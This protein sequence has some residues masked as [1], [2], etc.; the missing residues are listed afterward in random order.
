LIQP[1]YLSKGDIIH[2]VAPAKNIRKDLI[3]KSIK[4]LEK[5]GFGVRLNQDLL[6]REGFFAGT[7]A[8][9]TEDFENAINHPEA[10]AIMALRGGYGCTRIIDKIDFSPLIEKPKWIIG[11]SDLTAFHARLFR[12]GI[13]SIHGSMPIF[14]LNPGNEISYQ[15]LLDLLTGNKIELKLPGNTKNRE[16]RGEGKFI[17]GNLSLIIDLLGTKDELNTEGHLLFIEEVDEYLYKI[18]RML[19]H[20]KRAGKLEKISGL[21]IGH[22][23]NIKDTS[24]PFKQTVHN[25]ISEVVSDYNY[26]VAFNFPIGHE[27]ENIS[28]PYGRHA[29]F[30]VEENSV[31]LVFSS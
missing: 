27:N 18:D 7:D 9:R 31:N 12:M 3:L 13:E 20:L 28:V 15:S 24:D 14:F 10:K 23:S 19:Q 6:D 4:L 8:E 17:G 25:I 11:F 30:K 2:L 21:I 5:S 16:G 29:N 22:L 1:P 26:P